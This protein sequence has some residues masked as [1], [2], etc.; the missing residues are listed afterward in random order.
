[1]LGMACRMGARTR[2]NT[3]ALESDSVHWGCSLG[4]IG[5]SIV[6]AALDR[7]PRYRRS[8]GCRPV[9][10]TVVLGFRLPGKAPRCGVSA[11]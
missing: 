5:Y 11:A 8:N 10:F 1:M 6:T 4:R 7:I 3:I 9:I 2:S